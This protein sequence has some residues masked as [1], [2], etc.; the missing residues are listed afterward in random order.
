MFK[1]SIFSFALVL[2]VE[3]ISAVVEYLKHRLMR[4]MNRQSYESEFS[5]AYC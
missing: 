1:Q 2:L 3:A 4:Q 5:E